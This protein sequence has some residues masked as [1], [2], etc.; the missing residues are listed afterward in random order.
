MC[1]N[2]K[3]AHASRELKH[4]LENWLSAAGDVSH[5]PARA[6][7]APYVL[8]NYCHLCAGFAYKQIDPT[9]VKR[10]FIL[11]PSHHVRLGGC[12]LS[13]AKIYRTP[14]YD[15]TIDQEIY[16]ELY[17]SG[18]FEEM[19]IHTDEDEHSIE[20]HLPYIAKI[21]EN[22]QFTII[23][24]MVGSLTTDKEAI[25]GKIFS[26]YLAEP[27]NLFVISSDFCHWEHFSLP[28]QFKHGSIVK[29]PRGIFVKF[30][31]EL[32]SLTAMHTAAK[33][34]GRI[35][36]AEDNLLFQSLSSLEME[37]GMNIIEE[38]SPTGFVSYLKK[39]GN[40][41]CGRHPIGVLLNAVYTIQK[42]GNGHKMSLK[43][44][45][46]AQSSQCLSMSDSSVSYAAASLRLD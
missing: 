36:C 28:V 33:T 45:N 32:G 3:F 13:P 7:I 11:G 4:Q 25:Y 9:I 2:Q 17:S 40:T 20:M 12:A 26:K 1:E 8:Y 15:L 5:G 35:P 39:Y 30:I 41:I 18:L 21:M 38:L 43:F 34:T 6:I 42:T 31:H 29:T 23:P 16:E 44:L 27:C 46:Y 10:V 24:V 14:F 19:T 37:W 22:H